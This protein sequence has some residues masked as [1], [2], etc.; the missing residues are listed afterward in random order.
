MVARPEA[1]TVAS[2]VLRIADWAGLRSS[3]TIYNNSTNVVYLGSDES[4]TTSNGMPLPVGM[5]IV[6]AREYGDDPSQAVYAVA[7]S[8]SNNVR[9]WEGFGES[10]STVLSRL[11]EVLGK[12]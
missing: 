4:L 1:F 11:T 5:G 12:R 8:G 9:L 6:F 10:L 3:L 2:V 7:A